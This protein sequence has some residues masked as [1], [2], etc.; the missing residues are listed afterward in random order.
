[1]DQCLGSILTSSEQK[2]HYASVYTLS[3]PKLAT[4]SCSH[5]QNRLSF[6][7][8]CVDSVPTQGT[9]GV[10]EALPQWSCQRAAGD[11]QP[12]CLEQAVFLE[13]IWVFSQQSV[14]CLCC[15]EWNQKLIRGPSEERTSEQGTLSSRPQTEDV[16]GWMRLGSLGNLSVQKDRC[17]WLCS[18]LSYLLHFSALI[19]LSVKGA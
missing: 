11:S 15:G 6:L 13:T 1:M 16:E 8:T 19:F 9:S 14:V 18:S 4:H 12:T 3:A 17:L 7:C 10:W 2:W 5:G